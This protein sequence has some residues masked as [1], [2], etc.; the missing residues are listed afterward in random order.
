M[1]CPFLNTPSQQCHQLGWWAQMCPAV[2]LLGIYLE[3]IVS[4]MGQPLDSSY[5]CNPP[6][7]IPKPY[8]LY[9]TKFARIKTEIRETLEKKNA[10]R[11]NKITGSSSFLT[12]SYH[13]PFFVC[14]FL[15]PMDLTLLCILLLKSF[16]VASFFFFDLPHLR[17][18]LSK[19]IFVCTF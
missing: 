6:S 19:F 11:V 1:F 15:K 13:E 5:R 4:S 18:L 3:L 14:S 9:P 2:V 16:Y 12:W 7:Q 8:H 10:V 17:K